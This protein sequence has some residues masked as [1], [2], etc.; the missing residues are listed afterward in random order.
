MLVDD[1]EQE[2][3]PLMNE[4]LN[5][6]FEHTR[7]IGS[8]KGIDD[9]DTYPEKVKQLISRLRRIKADIIIKGII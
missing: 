8:Y 6:I 5:N 2:L 3:S 9:M 4:E 1:P 7:Q